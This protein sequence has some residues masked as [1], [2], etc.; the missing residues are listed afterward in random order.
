MSDL[1]ITRANVSD[2]ALLTRIGLQAF[3]HIAW[4]FLT[5][6]LDAAVVV[7][8]LDV[9]AQFEILIL[10]AFIDEECVA[11]DRCDAVGGSDNDAVLHLPHLGIALPF[12]EVAAVKQ[13][14]ESFAGFAHHENLRAKRH[15]Q[16][17]GDQKS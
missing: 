10:A 4:Q 1:T 2:A 11:F 5:T 17:C 7:A 14:H 12:A 8:Q 6:E 15:G 9:Q 3:H 13:R 16:Q